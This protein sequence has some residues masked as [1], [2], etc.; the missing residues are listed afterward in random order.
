MDG[1]NWLSDSKANLEAVLTISKDFYSFTLYILVNDGKAILMITMKLTLQTDSS[2]VSVPAPI[3]INVGNSQ[4]SLTPTLSQMSV[5]YLGVWINL[6]KSRSFIIINQC[7][8]EI[9]SCCN[10]LRNKH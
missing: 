8:K 3:K 5:R 6:T 7:H 10:L 9:F 1:T 2:G 4:L